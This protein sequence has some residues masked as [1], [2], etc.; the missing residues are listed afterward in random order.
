MRKKRRNFSSFDLA[1]AFKELGIV[2]LIEWRL[3]IEPISPGDFYYERIRRLRDHFDVATSERAKELLIDAICDE[4][5][6]HHPQLKMWKAAPIQSEDLTG[7]ADYVAAPKRRYLD[8]PLLCVVEAK[9]DDFEQ[10]LA[11]CL[12]EMKACQDSNAAVGNKIE[13]YGIVTNG[14]AWRFYKLSIEG[15]V[16]ESRLY[17]IGEIEEV[18]GCLHYVFAQCEN[19][20]A[21]FA[22]A[23]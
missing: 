16:Y 8:N 4:A 10:G 18:L 7:M 9:K 12:V 3:E 20:I 1:E 15:Q 6:L 23:A 17:A 13:I 22:K 5:L 11:Q 2:K 19:N 21:T 14:D